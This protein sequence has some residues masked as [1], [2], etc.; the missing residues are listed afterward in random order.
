MAKVITLSQTFPA[1]HPRKGE[2]TFFN[3][4]IWKSLWLSQ[5]PIY[6][7]LSNGLSYGYFNQNIAEIDPKHHTIRSGK[8][9]KDGDMASLRVWS[10]KPYNSPQIAI[11][12]DVKLRVLDFEINGFDVY[13]GGKPYC[14]LNETDE[15]FQTVCR[16]D[17][18]TFLEF[19]KW[20]NQ[21]NFYGQILIWNNTNLPY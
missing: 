5:M 11:A 4:K 3:E 14:K 18:L 10:G 16:N 20:F 2:S 17:G 19:D 6:H 13:I 9:W 15:K 21:L 1:Y 8:R 12:P 7:T